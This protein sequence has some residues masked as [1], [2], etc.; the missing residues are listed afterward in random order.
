M[1][2]RGRLHR[3]VRQFDNRTASYRGIHLLRY[4]VVR[5][6]RANRDIDLKSLRRNDELSEARER[7][8]IRM[9][10][11]N[12]YK[13][14]SR[15]APGLLR[16]RWHEEKRVSLRSPAYEFYK[17]Y[18]QTIRDEITGQQFLEY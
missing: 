13:P 1:A 14:H 10:D 8:S 17:H 12:S 9:C 6:K 18:G 5:F 7:R 2:A 16:P 11:L 15:A 3:F 4:V